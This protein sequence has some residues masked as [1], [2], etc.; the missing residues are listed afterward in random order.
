MRLFVAFLCAVLGLFACDD[1]ADGGDPASD[2]MIM[3]DGGVTPDG[4]A[5]FETAYLVFSRIRSPDGRTMYASIVP[6]L[7]AG[8]LDLANA[9]EQSGVS[10]ARSHEGKL[11]AFDGETGVITRYVIDAAGGFEVDTLDDGTEARLSF[12]RLGVSLFTDTIVFTAPDRAFY[13]DTLFNDLVIEWDPQAMVINRSFS[14]GMFRDGFD[15]SGG[16]T[17]RVGEYVVLPVTWSSFTLGRVIETAAIAVLDLAPGGEVTVIEDE[18]CVYTSSVFAYDGAVYAFN[19]NFAGLVPSY[20]PNMIPPACLLRWQ[21]G[22]AAFEADYLL[23]LQALTDLPHVSGAASRGDGTFVT[24]VYVS[25]IDPT[26]LEP[27]ELLDGAFW[28]R[29]LVDLPGMQTRLLDDIAPGALSAIGWTVDGDY[30]V[31]RFDD[32]EGRSTLY[33]LGDR[34]EELLS[35]AGEIFKVERIR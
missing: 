2:A 35:V 5:S 34:A 21:P 16:Q 30:L 3:G 11:F 19:D 18:R 6:D 33:R 32:A 15:V 7:A 27:L 4:G 25:D 24:Q 12:A 28:Q 26:T 31:S 22:A 29:A 17:A 13:F 23:D 1:G 20:S 14:A 8:Q 10:R 9:L